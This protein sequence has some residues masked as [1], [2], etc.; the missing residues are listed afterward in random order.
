MNLYDHL[1]VCLMRVL[2]T[3]PKN[4]VD[5]FESLSI[6]CKKSGFR[7]ENADSPG[8][9]QKVPDTSLA[10]ELAKIQIKLFERPLLEDGSGEHAP[11]E[12]PSGEIPDI[13]DISHLW[14]W[15]GLTLG[16]EETFLLFLSLKQLVEEKSLKSVR[17]WGKIF[18]LKSNY[19]I[20]EGE[21]REG[22]ID[23]EDAVVNGTLASDEAPQEEAE[24]AAPSENAAANPEGST[25][26]EDEEGAPKPKNKVIPPLPKEM[27][28][29]VNKYIYYVTP[30]PGGPWTRLP[31][32]IP[33][34][35]QIARKI[36]KYFTGDLAHKIISYPAF[37]ATEAQYLR[38]Q[39][40]RIS[41]ATVVSPAGYYIFDPEEA[42][43]EDL[44][45]NTSI[46]INPEYEGQ[47]NEA[48]LNPANWVHH[49][50]YILP[51]GRVT[52]ENPL[53]SLKKEGNE[54]EEDEEDGG[55]DAGSQE[56]N[57]E[58]PQPEA[59][60]PILSPLSGDEDH[61]D[62]PA[63]TSRICSTLSPP[64]F[65]PVVMRST[66]WPGAAVVAFND[67]FTNIY[68]GDGLKDLGN[69]VQHFI[70]PKLPE[71]QS[72]YTPLGA[73]I[74]EQVDPTVEEEK[75]YEEAL[76]AKLEE[77]EEEEEAAEGEA[78]EGDD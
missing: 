75:A 76:K 71:I 43:G 8:A 39:I 77:K 9:L 18:G 37:D 2:E 27:R 44:E 65:T 57:E 67:K 72:E 23:E 46:I 47:P 30:Y 26:P 34:K 53:A 41:G 68:V 42:D 17:L 11:I 32:V 78:E 59:G 74:T 19:I 55:S 35:M 1:T 56:D 52:W 13:M 7:A 45:H 61:G 6:E 51:Q 63:W 40:A 73:E 69:P 29:G 31:D 36:R 58:A 16:S 20:I 24:Q 14:E 48:L 64:K 38:C 25:N 15:G 21:L 49:V 62:I 60:P 33:E 70:P 5:I 4:A 54:G 22:T 3:R 50:P 66:R 10:A 12:P 28:T